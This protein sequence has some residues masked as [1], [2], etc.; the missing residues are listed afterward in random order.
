MASGSCGSAGR[1][2][3]RSRRRCS[4]SRRRARSPRPASAGC[5]IAR[6]A[7]SIRCSRSRCE[8][9]RRSPARTSPSCTGTAARTT[10]SGCSRRCVERGARVAEP[11]EF[12]RRA[13]ANGKLDLVRAE[14]LLEVIHAG[15]ERAWRLA[16]AN[17]GGRARRATSR[18]SSGARSRCSPRSRAASTFPRTISM[19][20]AMR[21]SNASS[22]DLEAAVRAFAD[23][24]RIGAC[25]PRRNHGR[26]GRSGQRRQVVAAQRP[27]RTRAR[28]RRG[29]A[30]ND[31]RLARDNNELERRCRDAGRHGRTPQ[32]SLEPSSSAG[33]RSASRALSLPTWWSWST[34]EKPRGMTVNGTAIGRYRSGA[35]RSSRLL[36]TSCQC[37]RHLD[38][39]SSRSPRSRATR[40][41]SCRRC[42]PRRKRT[43]DG[44]DPSTASADDRGS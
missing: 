27:G 19:S 9:R 21:G 33:S 42:R 14:A 15:S 24:F 39:N 18:R 7:R 34:T 6:A 38:R 43:A 16:Q 44:H 12:T 28:A 40:A 29:R 11:G 5:A 3:S 32:R 26:A 22:R 20:R 1:G 30:G 13:V 41:G 31:P 2:R 25:H 23:G 10:S 37:A 17:L 35:R 8:R 4:A 36:R